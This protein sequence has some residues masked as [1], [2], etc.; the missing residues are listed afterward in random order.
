MSQIRAGDAD[1]GYDEA[2]TGPAVV[3]IHAGLADRRMWDHQFNTLSASHR[4]IRYDWRGYGDSSDSS[5]DVERHEDLLALMDALH[6]ERA[7]LVGCSFGGAHAVDAALT[8]PDR[9]TGL[10]LIGSALSGHAWPP[11][12]VALMQEQVRSSVPADRLEKYHNRTASVVEPGDITAMA[13]ANVRLM[14]AGPDRTPADLTADVWDLAVDMC[15]GVYTRDWTGPAYTERHVDPP[16]KGRLGEI[17]VPTLV[18]NGLADVPGVQ[19]VADLLMDGITGARRLDLP[20]TGH[21]PPLERPTE[22]TLALVEF[23]SSIDSF[24]KP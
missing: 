13:E 21:L 9:V 15:R 2:G 14:V 18:I 7:T 22:V 10:A 23:L 20:N 8:A 17:K 1:L 6:V 19:A 12:M 24:R 5:G 11:E 4:V 16:A 3:F